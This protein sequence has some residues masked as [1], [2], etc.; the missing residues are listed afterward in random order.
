MLIIKMQMKHPRVCLLGYQGKCGKYCAI[1]IT[2]PCELIALK[3][4]MILWKNTN[5]YTYVSDKKRTH[6]RHQSVWF[7]LKQKILNLFKTI[8]SSFCSFLVCILRWNSG[9]C[10]PSRCSATELHRSFPSVV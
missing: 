2:T 8:L 10:R 4:I 1:E 5:M 7:I 9:T 6:N 3:Y